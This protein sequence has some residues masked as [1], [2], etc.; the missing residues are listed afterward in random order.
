MAGQPSGSGS[1]STTVIHQAGSSSSSTQAPTLHLVLQPRPQHHVTWTDDTVDNEH[2]NRRKSKKCCIYK[3]PRDF[4]ESSSSSSS[5][6]DGAARPSNVRRR[7]HP[8]RMCPYG[9]PVDREG[10]GGPGAPAGPPDG[11]GSGSGPEG[12]GA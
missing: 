7:P 8:N 11:S 12:Q 1:A 2:L 5:E 6:D 3:K 9:Q 10:P 4:G